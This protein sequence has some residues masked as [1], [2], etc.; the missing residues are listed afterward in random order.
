MG[1]RSRRILEWFGIL[2]PPFFGLYCF[3]RVEVQTHFDLMQGGR[4]D[5]R[6]VIF[7]LEHWFR[8]LQGR[9]DLLS[10]P[11][12]FPTQKTLGYSDVIL[13][14]VPLYSS[15]RSLHLDIYTSTQFACILSTVLNY[16]AC[17]F[18][19]RKGP[20][21]G[22]LASSLGAAFFTF[23]SAN[24][25]Q[26][27]HF[28]YVPLFLIPLIFYC[29]G[30]CYRRPDRT[31]PYLAGAAFLTALQ[32]MTCAYLGWF[33]IFWGGLFLLTFLAFPEPRQS[34][35]SFVGRH[36]GALAGALGAFVL[37]MV[38]FFLIFLAGFTR[39]APR[40]YAE[41]MQGNP[42]PLS[43]LWMGATNPTWG[44]LSRLGPFLEMPLEGEKRIGLG[45]VFSVSWLFLT[46]GGLYDLWRMGRGRKPVLFLKL[47]G[48]KEKAAVFLLALVLSVDLFGLLA[49]QAGPFSLWRWVYEIV[50]GAK[51]LRVVSRFMIF[52]VLP[53]TLALSTGFQRLLDG[54]RSG[55]RGLRRSA[56]AGLLACLVLLLFWEQ[57]GEGTGLYF[58][59]KED[60][61]RILQMAAQIPRDASVFFIAVDPGIKD[62]RD[63]EFQLDAMLTAQL[64][65][66]PT[67]NGYS[68]TNPPLWFLNSLRDPRYLWFVHQW[69][70]RNRLDAKVFELVLEK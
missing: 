55:P 43:F 48:G 46:G 63:D 21:L 6:Y 66:I 56:R 57:K 25:H 69:V 12:F 70:V 5:G 60:Q 9:A 36:G 24:Y 35:L 20:G 31:L 13:A 45:L 65:G 61:I 26:L 33:L 2:L 18:F 28:D 17:F 15:L 52:L 50:P 44:W 30:S 3:Y 22:L 37:F 51:S 54:I 42:V 8:W 7:I 58:N 34:V 1:P 39:N 23:N 40:S 49:L 59:K 16:S 11:Y 32:F 38:P 62:F 14:L 19:L 53:M 41:V 10:P 47:G 29:L 4:A 27:N 68:G 64:T 67:I